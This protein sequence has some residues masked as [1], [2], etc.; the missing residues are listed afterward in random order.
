MNVVPR[1]SVVLCATGGTCLREAVRALSAQAGADDI[2]R[3]VVARQGD[4]AVTALHAD[5]WRVAW[6]APELSL[7]QL[8]LDALRVASG[9]VVAITTDRFV[10]AADWIARIRTAHANP[11]EF[12]VVAGAIEVNADAP[13][14]TRAVYGAEYAAFGVSAGATA[15]AAPAANLSLTRPA[16]EALLHHA[17]VRAWDAEWAGHFRSCGIAVVRDES[18]I[19]WLVHRYTFFG[20]AHERFHFSRTLSG[21]RAGGWSLPRRAASAC[22]MIALPLLLTWRLIVA[23]WRLRLPAAVW[24]ALPLMLIFTMP[25]TIGDIA[26]VLGGPGGSARKVG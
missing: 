16:V 17:G 24:R 6:V 11:A 25:W 14:V 3:L 13:L 9:A 19:V 26:G 18:R 4:P 1:V 5:R 21:V 22:L 15:D 10:P 20:F 12:S 8:F 7:G 2:E 23:G